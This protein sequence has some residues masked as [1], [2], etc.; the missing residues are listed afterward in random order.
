MI[1]EEKKREEADRMCGI[2]EKEMVEG[3]PEGNETECPNSEIR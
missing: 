3:G 2:P 1:G